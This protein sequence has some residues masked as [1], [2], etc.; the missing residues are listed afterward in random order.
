MSMMLSLIGLTGTD[1]T[2]NMPQ[3]SGKTVFGMLPDIWIGLMQAYRPETGQL[4]INSA[5]DN[6][7]ATLYLSKFASHFRGCDGEAIESLGGVLD[8]LQMSK[9]SQRTRDAL[10]TIPRIVC[11]LRNVNWLLQYW[12]D[13]RTAADPLASDAADGSA[14]YGFL[15]LK[16][17][18]VT[19]AA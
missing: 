2:R 14:T 9:L 6:V 19:Y 4:D 8:R 12:R 1:F 3:L 13:A 10:P 5:A 11:T 15:K 17:G 7:V 18:A 16:G